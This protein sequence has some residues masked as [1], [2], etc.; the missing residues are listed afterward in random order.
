MILVVH[1][2]PNAKDTKVVDKLDDRTFIIALHAPATEGKANEELVA[3][4]SDKL[5]FAKTF[6]N[7]SRG[8]H[9]R[10]KHL[11]IPDGTDVRSL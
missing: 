9:S 11:E 4:L 10:V 3:F 1:V 8:N 2:K 5:K 6:I 7:L